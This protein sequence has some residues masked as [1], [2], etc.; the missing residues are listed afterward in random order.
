MYSQ[1]IDDDTSSEKT[2]D[3]VEVGAAKNFLAA[4]RN[5]DLVL[6][7]EQLLAQKDTSGYKRLSVDTQAAKLRRTVSSPDL[8]D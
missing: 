5:G 6:N 1:T 3:T 2:M 8:S 7:P 4:L